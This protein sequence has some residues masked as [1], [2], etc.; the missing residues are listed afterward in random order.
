MR[1]GHTLLDF[2]RSTLDKGFA[3][4]QP[5]RHIYGYDEKMYYPASEPRDAKRG[6]TM[7][8][9]GVCAVRKGAHYALEA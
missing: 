1:Y 9:V 8:F 4:E 7:P 2:A 3:K 5:A 6:L